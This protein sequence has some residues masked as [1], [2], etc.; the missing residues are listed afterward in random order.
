MNEIFTL[1]VPVD[2]MMN[3]PVQVQIF[4]QRYVENGRKFLVSIL[5]AVLISV[6]ASPAD[7]I[8]FLL[9]N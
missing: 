6:Q 4:Q 1:I 7:V 9:I 3:S 8:F 5:L 2:N